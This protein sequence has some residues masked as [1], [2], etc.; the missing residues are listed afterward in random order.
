MALTDGARSDE[1]V[2]VL[3]ARKVRIARFGV[4]LVGV[5]WRRELIEP[6][7]SEKSSDDDR[8]K[9]K[10]SD[11]KTIVSAG[12]AYEA[13]N[14]PDVR[15]R[16]PTTAAGENVALS[17][18][19]PAGYGVVLTRIGAFERNEKLPT[20]PGWIR[21]PLASSVGMLVSEAS[22]VE[23]GA[24]FVTNGA[25]LACRNKNLTWREPGIV[26]RLT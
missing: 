8:S 20:I 11:V 26:K 10:R 17:K 24:L 3:S 7:H 4:P 16:Y 14:E 23:L 15:P 25:K 5:A 19:E 21:D 13:E 9:V 1:N 12:S 18:F 22:K 2:P 6:S